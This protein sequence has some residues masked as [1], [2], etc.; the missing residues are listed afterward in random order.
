LALEM[1]QTLDFVEFGARVWSPAHLQ[2]QGGGESEEAITIVT[3]CSVDRLPKLQALAEAW[4]GKISCAV[5]VPAG[6]ADAATALAAIDELHAAVSRGCAAKLGIVLY[7]EPANSAPHDDRT[8]W[9]AALYPINALRNAALRAAAT[10]FVF[11]LDIDFVPSPGAHDAL[12]PL[13][14]RLV[15]GREA[16]VVPAIEVQS[17]AALPA[18]RAE[19]KALFDSGRAEGFHMTR[20]PRG[21][22]PTRFE[23]WFRA[24]EGEEY[25]VGYSLGFE[26]YVVA[27]RAEVP[28]YDARFRGYGLN[29]VVHLYRMATVSKFDFVVACS[30]HFVMAAEHEASADYRKTYGPSCDPLQ[31]ARIQAL[32]DVAIEDMDREMAQNMCDAEFVGPVVETNA[33]AK[34]DDDSTFDYKMLPAM[35]FATLIFGVHLITYANAMWLF[36]ATRTFKTSHTQIRCLRPAAETPEGAVLDA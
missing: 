33:N 32:F 9:A 2:A 14:R 13:A 8:A 18:T 24:G 34:T 28:A 30:G 23:H 36:A 16:L 19:A 20:Y 7:Q 25:R 21:H 15:K 5:H 12:L 3:Q 1:R 29:K 26:P 4:S 17:G 22:Q 27:R 6:E 11:L 35:N 10:E 31:A